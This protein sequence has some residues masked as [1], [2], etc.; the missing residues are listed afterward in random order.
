MKIIKKEGKMD[1][2]DQ[3]LYMNDVM[4]IEEAME[5]LRMTRK[6]LLKLSGEGK[7]DGAVKIGKQ[8]RYSRRRL[9]EMIEGK[10]A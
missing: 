2:K 6:T 7:I 10:S 1:Q 3:N 4:T 9:F 8:W 5:Y